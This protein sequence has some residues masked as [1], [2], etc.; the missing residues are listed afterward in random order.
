MKKLSERRENPYYVSYLLFGQED[1]TQRKLQWLSGNGRIFLS[2]SKLKTLKM[3]PGDKVNVGLTRQG[4]I[5]AMSPEVI[6]DKI[7]RIMKSE[8]LTKHDRDLLCYFY[9]DFEKLTEKRAID[10]AQMLGIPSKI[11]DI[12]NIKKNNAVTSYIND[13]RLIIHR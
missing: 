4:L 7:V 9:N 1:F 11:R 13:E 3:K 8:F 12:L 2:D 10:E 6:N 5:L